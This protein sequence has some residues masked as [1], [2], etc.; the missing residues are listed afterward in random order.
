MTTS[1]WGVLRL[2]SWL[3]AAKCL[4]CDISPVLC[5]PSISLVASDAFRNGSSV[6]ASNDRPH[7]GSRSMLMV[8]PRF[9]AAPLPNS[10]EPI[11]WP[12]WRAN[13]GSN[14][15]AT[16]T[17]AGSWVTPLRPSATPAGP[18]SSPSGGIEPHDIWIPGIQ[19]TYGL[20]PGVFGPL[21]VPCPSTRK[22]SWSRVMT[23]ISSATRWAIGWLESSHGQSD[24]CAG[25]AFARAAV[26][27]PR[28]ALTRARA[29]VAC[30]RATAEPASAVNVVTAATA[31][32]TTT[33]N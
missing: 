26:A 4:T 7:R 8:G 25:L 14:V 6:N 33:A 17:P 20:P 18:S 1:S 12:Y 30:G 9:T 31:T 22:S 3:Y 21:A 32:A 5:T 16:P 24:D 23:L 11:T 19:N 27:C 2:V 29:D 15:A 28:P 10:S 13:D